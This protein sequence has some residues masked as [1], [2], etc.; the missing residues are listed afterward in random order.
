[1]TN[2]DFKSVL[3]GALSVC[4]FLLL[5]AQKSNELGDIVVNSITVR[6]D[7]SGGGFIEFFNKDNTK[8]AYIGTSKNEDGMIMLLDEN[9]DALLFAGNSNGGGL[10]Q[11]YYKG[12]NWAMIGSN[13]E[14]GYFNLREGKENVFLGAGVFDRE[15]MILFSDRY[16]NLIWG[17]SS[18]K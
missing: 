13:N 7:G 1:M 14:G 4:C 10:V 18:I 12:D 6:D 2:L 16:G 5:T 15:T 3:V 8:T 9:E 17:E 11:T